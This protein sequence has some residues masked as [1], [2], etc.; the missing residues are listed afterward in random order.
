[1]GDEQHR[2]ALRLPDL[3]QQLLHEPAGLVVERPERLVEQED[4]GVVGQRPRDRHALLHPA[5]E[6][7]RQVPLEARE[8]HA[9]HVVRH[10]PLAPRARNARLAQA[11]G[12]VVGHR[13]PRKE[14][15][16]L[17]HHAPVGARAL[18]HAPAHRDLAR[19]GRVEA[20]HQAQERALAAARGAQQRHELPFGHVERDGRQRLRRRAAAQAGEAARDPAQADRRAHS[21]LQAKSRRLSRLEERVRDQPDHADDDDAEDDLP[22]LQERLA[23]DDHV[24]DPRGRADQLGH[25]HVGPGPAQHEAQDLRDLRRGGGQEHAPHH[26]A[27]ARAERVGGLH[28]L[29]PRAAHRHG[30]HQ[31][32]LEH[33]ADEDHEQ[34]LRLADPGPQ[35]QERD[36]GRR[37]QVAREAHEGFQERLHGLPRAHGDARGH[38]HGGGQREAPHDAP[39]RDGDVG[40][41]A[42]LAQEAPAVGQHGRRA[43]QKEGG[44]EP[45]EGRDRPGADEEHEEQYAEH[46]A[47][48]RPHRLERPHRE[49]RPPPDPQRGGVLGR[50]RAGRGGPQPAPLSLGGRAAHA[51]PRPRPGTA[52][53]RARTAPGP[54][55]AWQ[56]SGAA[57]RSRGPPSRG[58]R[59]RGGGLARAAKLAARLTPSSSCRSARRWAGPPR[60]CRSR[61]GA[62]RPCCRTP[63]C[64]PT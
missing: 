14:R 17:E 11:E 42:V 36:E 61:P 16:G 29:A 15:V 20:R 55:D 23:V 1:M 31:G 60:S 3:Q 35:D 7:L 45:A 63:G 27:V 40:P 6:L 38:G 18:H 48:A 24:P 50:P 37:R 30:H 52:G 39:H 64:R 22:R 13:E 43:R 21:R 28:E 8:P 19:R 34:L 9:A 44:N 10:D 62:A 53:A 25:D 59:G 5:R 12:D 51:G 32:D 33:R 56:T 2:L 41:E 46:H 4:G 58:R 54:H 57:S 49:P 47:R 26:A